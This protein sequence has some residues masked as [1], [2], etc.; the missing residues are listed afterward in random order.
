MFLELLEYNSLLV[1]NNHAQTATILTKLIQH[2]LIQHNP[3]REHRLLFIAQEEIKVDHGQVVVMTE[4]YF[5]RKMLLLLLEATTDSI[6]H[7][8][9]FLN[10]EC[11][12]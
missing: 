5:V 1:G 8:L 9:C 3:L 4:L 12:I 6:N 11:L 2:G 10:F 7:S